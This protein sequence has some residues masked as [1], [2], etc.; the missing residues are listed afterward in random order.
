MFVYYST[1]EAV[2]K[3]NYRI[4]AKV[5]LC[6]GWIARSSRW[7]TDLAIRRERRSVTFAAMAI[8]TIAPPLHHYCGTGGTG[9]AR[10]FNAPQIDGEGSK[11]LPIYLWGKHAVN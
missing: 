9:N 8:T 1:N 3:I 2:C 11:A 6:S 5:A 4:G 10:G 7:A